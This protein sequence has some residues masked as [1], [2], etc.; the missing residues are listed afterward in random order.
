MLNSMYSTGVIPG[1]EFLRAPEIRKPGIAFGIMLRCWNCG[2]PVGEKRADNTFL[3]SSNKVEVGGIPL[4][5]GVWRRCRGGKNNP[6]CR[7]V[8]LLPDEWTKPG[9]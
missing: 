1:I 9:N 5:A 8:N 7:A 3:V 4:V 6:G 2:T